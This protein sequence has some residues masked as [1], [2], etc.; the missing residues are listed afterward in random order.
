MYAMK[1]KLDAEAVCLLLKNPPPHEWTMERFIALVDAF[2]RRDPAV[3]SLPELRRISQALTTSSSRRS[4]QKNVPLFYGCVFVHP[5]SGQEMNIWVRRVCLLRA[6]KEKKDQA[7]QA[8]RNG[9][10]DRV[11]V[12]DLKEAPWLCEKPNPEMPSLILK[13]PGKPNSF[14][15]YLRV[16]ESTCEKYFESHDLDDKSIYLAARAESGLLMLDGAAFV[17]LNYLSSAY[18]KFADAKG[19]AHFELS[20]L[21]LRSY[22]IR[23]YYDSIGRSTVASG[24]KAAPPAKSLKERLRRPTY[25]SMGVTAFDSFLTVC[26]RSEELESKGGNAWSEALSE[27]Q[28]MMLSGTDFVTLEELQLSFDAFCEQR[29]SFKYELTATILNTHNMEVFAHNGVCA[30]TG[31]KHVALAEA[32]ADSA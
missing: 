17:P 2:D 23:T 7:D 19:L 3:E 13:H 5:T 4:S 22:S 16:C 21:M 14:E 25:E 27:S 31:L 12:D 20:P 29:S 32:V 15:E 9:D 18:K 11:D 10:L 1:E 26:D 28:H 30:V 24:F 6:D 8:F